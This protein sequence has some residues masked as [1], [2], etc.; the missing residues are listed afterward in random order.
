MGG[1]VRAPRGRLGVERRPQRSRDQQ[2][3]RPAR[4]PDARGHLVDPVT[5]PV[6]VPVT[7]SF[8]GPATG[9][10][11]GP[12][13]GSLT[14]LFTGPGAVPRCAC[15]RLTRSEERRVGKE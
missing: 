9:S 5:I 6:T 11:T 8:T 1:G 14:G 13:T 15:P 7:R 4:Q 12:A 3:V 2:R 10:L